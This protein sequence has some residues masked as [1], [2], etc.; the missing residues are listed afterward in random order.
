MHFLR[1]VQGAAHGPRLRQMSQLRQVEKYLAVASGDRNPAGVL[2]V[3]AGLPAGQ[4]LGAGCQ[5]G[6]PGLP[7]SA[8]SPVPPVRAGR[9]QAQ[10]R[11][12]T[13]RGLFR[14]PA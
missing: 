5:S 4:R 6:E 12:R 1:F 14:W 10:W 8:R 11:D 3:A 9:R 7:M 2:S 13:G